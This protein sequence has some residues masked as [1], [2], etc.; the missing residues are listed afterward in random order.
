MKSN[1]KY[2]QPTPEGSFSSSNP[3][4]DKLRSFVHI[5]LLTGNSGSLIVRL[6]GAFFKHRNRNVCFV[7]Q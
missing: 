2:F 4:V 3:H 5:G 7:D 6:S 1:L